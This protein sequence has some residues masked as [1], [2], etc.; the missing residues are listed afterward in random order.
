MEEVWLVNGT[1]LLFLCAKKR[2]DEGKPRNAP[3]DP[4]EAG[5]ILNRAV[6]GISANGKQEG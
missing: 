5:G 2:R 1:Y 4:R 6:P 3:V